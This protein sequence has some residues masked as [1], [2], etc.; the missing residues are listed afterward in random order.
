MD[1]ANTQIDCEWKLYDTETTPGIGVFLSQLLPRGAR[2]GADPKFMPHHLWNEW[3]SALNENSQKLVRINR[4]LVDVGWSSQR[5]KPSIFDIN[6]HEPQFSGEKWQE[7]VEAVRLNLANKNC[8]SIIITS[9]TEI[10][11]L[12]NLRGNDYRYMPVFKVKLYNLIY[13]G[14]N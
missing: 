2:V 13:F 10:A 1:L 4:N 7:K 11:Y 6:I 14:S 12:L 3:E 5:P 9:L 8:E